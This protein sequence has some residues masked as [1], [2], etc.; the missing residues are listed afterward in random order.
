MGVPSP[1]NIHTLICKY[2]CVAFMCV[3]HTYSIRSEILGQIAPDFRRYFDR[4]SP[5]GSYCCTGAGTAL[6]FAA[7]RGD[8]AVADALLNATAPADRPMLSLSLPLSL[9]LS[10]SLSGCL[11]VAVLMSVLHLYWPAQVGGERCRRRSPLRLPATQAGT[12][13]SRWVAGL[14]IRGRREEGGR[15]GQWRVG[16][17][18]TGAEYPGWLPV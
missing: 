14:F 18:P 16:H 2:V 11:S 17:G 13:A 4:I 8:S 9:S 5:N 10:V 12:R 3:S 7:A 6:H 1:Y 15:G